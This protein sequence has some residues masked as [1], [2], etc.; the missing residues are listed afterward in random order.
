MQNERKKIKINFVLS[1]IYK[2]IYKL[3]F[4]RYTKWIIKSW[5]VIKDKHKD[6]FTQNSFECNIN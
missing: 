1:D 2:K 6:K 4:F 3:F 5:V